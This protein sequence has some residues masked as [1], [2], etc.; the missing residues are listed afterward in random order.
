MTK[1]NIIQKLV[2][3][4]KTQLRQNSK[5]L[6]ISLALFGTLLSGV[7]GFQVIQ[8]IEELSP[9]VASAAIFEGGSPNGGGNTVRVNRIFTGSNASGNISATGGQV[10][11]V[12]DYFSNTGGQ[13]VS[14][15]QMKTTLPAGFTYVPGSFINCQNP[16]STE[17]NC[18]SGWNGAQRDQAFA[19]YTSTGL[20]PAAGLYENLNIDSSG[21]L[22][23]GKKRYIQIENDISGSADNTIIPCK[24]I[25]NNSATFT[26][27]G[28]RCAGKNGIVT[29]SKFKVDTFNRKFIQIRT[30]EAG[31]GGNIAISCDLKSDNNPTF[32]PSDNYSGPGNPRCYG[33]AY[34]FDKSKPEIF[35]RR[36]LQYQVLD[37]NISFNSTPLLIGVDKPGCK[38][39]ADNSPAGANLGYCNS[40][41]INRYNYTSYIMKIDLLDTTRSLGYFEYSITAP[42]GG[43]GQFGSDVRMISASG[44]GFNDLNVGA[45]DSFE[46]GV[47]NSIN[48]TSANGNLTNDKITSLSCT[49]LFN[50]TVFTSI[51]CNVNLTTNGLTGGVNITAQTNSAP[52]I[53][54]GGCTATPANSTVT[55]ATCS[56]KAPINPTSIV[57]LVATARGSGSGGL[58]GDNQSNTFQLKPQACLNGAT[59]SPICNVCPANQSN[60]PRAT[61]ADPLAN[62]NTSICVP[63]CNNDAIN[64]TNFP[65][66]RCTQCPNNMAYTS[67]SCN[68]CAN[69]GCS[70]TSVCPA[71]VPCNNTSG[72]TI[73]TL[74]CNNYSVCANGASN[75]VACNGCVDD[76][77]YFDQGNPAPNGSCQICPIG[78]SCSGGI[79]QPLT[80]PENKYCVA[81]T[82]IPVDCG[83]GLNSPAGS[84]AVTDCRKIAKAGNVLGPAQCSPPSIPV[85]QTITCEWTLTAG[86]DFVQGPLFGA[87]MVTNSNPNDG[88]YGNGDQ[89]SIGG[90]ILTC[91]N[92]PTGGSPLGLKR[93]ML[94]RPGIEY[95][96]VG[97]NI[98]VTAGVPA[99]SC[100]AGQS[101]IAGICNSCLSGTFCAGGV[102]PAVTCP[103]NS[104]CTAN[105]T[106][107]T[108]CGVDLIAPAGSAS[109]GACVSTLC[110]NGAT[111]FTACN[112]CVTGSI[113]TSNACT[114]CPAGQIVTTPST[115]S[116]ITSC[117][118]SQYLSAGACV[119]CTAGNYCTGGAAPQTAC[120]SATPISSAG[121]TSA[122]QCTATP[123]TSCPAGQYLSSGS[124]LTC[125]AGNYCTGGTSGQTACPS[126]TPVSPAG[127]TTLAQCTATP[128]VTCTAGQYLV[129]GS[130]TNC[131]AGSYCTGGTSGST[132]CPV[133]TFC[134]AGSP[135]FQNCVAGT[136]S[137]AGS[138]SATQCTTPTCPNGATNAIACD[139]CP[140][141]KYLLAN[142]CTACNAG[143]YCTGGTNGQVACPP[144]TFCVANV[145]TFTSC[146]PSQTSPASSV[147][148][149]ACTQPLCPNE[150][151]NSPQCSICVSGS[152]IV[153]ALNAC[154]PCLPG[155]YITA[156]NTVCSP[157]PAGKTC[158]GGASVPIVCPANNYCVESSIN[159]VACPSPKISPAG[160][161]SV[162]ACVFPPC[163]NGATNE[164]TCTVCIAGSTIPTTGAN[165][166][167]CP[168]GS[169][170]TA[171]VCTPCTAGYSC[172]GGVN[173][174]V[175]CPANTFCPTGSPAPIPC[176]NPAQVSAALST[177]AS[178]CVYPD[179]PNGAVNNPACSTCAAGSTFAPTN[180]TPCPAGSSIVNI[181]CTPC[182]AGSTCAGEIGRAHV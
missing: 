103:A 171:S 48:L 157:C 73:N 110:G 82:V 94:H 28:V 52:I 97:G 164:P 177:S 159:G 136:I 170:I 167:P 127:S 102:L 5:I 135:S 16:S 12:R 141:G 3:L 156:N 151:T 65:A 68:V 181:T 105:S 23:I 87:V 126:A 123:L 121:A 44:S 116:G 43:N 104:Y 17:F 49:P 153:V 98:T 32:V 168:A 61:G 9:V 93:V 84:G 138:T 132:T 71:D 95:I 26:D 85:G 14:N 165:C 47:N 81:G 140:S 22:E 74:T 119:T 51:T 120:P 173:A 21:V 29:G 2:E 111:N 62:D 125:T 115:C 166:T 18:S 24:L 7:A 147:S 137:P 122:T 106:T 1:I 75:P 100:A 41:G 152:T 79:A 149:T 64:P 179:C 92:I 63:N 13:S 67:G 15:A 178:A 35:G 53:D 160:S 36:Y 113:Y 88:L 129:A 99:T 11:Q 76:S 155:N 58:D 31:N 8:R 133:N 142:N 109:V 96:A 143:F 77:K 146:P 174:P 130:C 128:I 42:A 163:P 139:S 46:P 91:A 39:Y 19:S 162:A 37:Q 145:S 20:A 66:T 182:P 4:T 54:N 27:D 148:Q 38:L 172:T 60:V 169:S 72:C 176:Q 78:K 112:V 131:P 45:R 50:S 10:I 56:F 161:T 154:T 34:E 57:N 101:L 118:A 30:D 124:C 144:N 89:C 108:T 150:A 25:A 117:P 70:N 6:T 180:C 107:F 69:G 83:A 114:P 90:G 59:N 134:P 175:A 80:C 33:R 86:T 55:T 40:P 158:A